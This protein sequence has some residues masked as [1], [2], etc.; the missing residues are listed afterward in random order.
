M[1][2]TAGPRNKKI[3]RSPAGASY[4]QSDDSP[5]QVIEIPPA[6]MQ[7]FL[8]LRFQVDGL[9]ERFND[10]QLARNHEKLKSLQLG[11][12]H[13]AFAQAA[14]YHGQVIGSVLRPDKLKLY[15]KSTKEAVTTI[16]KEPDSRFQHILG[17]SAKCKQLQ[18]QNLVVALGFDFVQTEMPFPDAHSAQWSDSNGV[19]ILK[20]FWKSIL[21]IL[22]LG[23]RDDKQEIC[24]EG[25]LFS[26]GQ[27]GIVN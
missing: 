21:L 22:S 9:G 6:L 3:L 24:A 10:L 4:T 23:S 26:S 25:R 12:I 11:G 2:P 18:D 1:A 17:L 15:V 5:S 16:S 7:H 20:A 14:G 19:K 27:K 13:A 8:E